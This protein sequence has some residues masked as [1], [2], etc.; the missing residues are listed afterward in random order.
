MKTLNIVGY[1]GFHNFGDDLMLMGLL[2][3]LSRK[4][5]GQVRVFV[6]HKEG[7]EAFVTRWRNLDVGFVSL[8]KFTTVLLPYYIFSASITIWCGGTCLYE[9]PSD[10]LFRGLKWI[11]RVAMYS[12]ISGRKLLLINIGVNRIISDRA[13]EIIRKMIVRRSTQIS[14][15]D[16]SSLENLKRISPAAKSVVLGGDLAFLN[17]IESVQKSSKNDHII[18]CGH[19]Q[20]ADNSD[21]VSFYAQ[22][23]SE[24]SKILGRSIV[25]VS[26]HDGVAGDGLF[27]NRIKERM[28]CQAVCTQY[29]SGD[30]QTLADLFLNSYCVISMRLHGVVFAE[31][32]MKPSIGIA[33]SDKVRYFVE[34]TNTVSSTRIKKVGEKLTYEDI[35]SIVKSYKADKS[36]IEKERALAVSG[37]D[38][39]L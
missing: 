38:A 12:E 10:P 20:Y 11:G 8:N 16:E 26:L 21:V 6:K 2:D 7:L 28:E 9:D 36:F 37:I 24:I 29:C 22:A 30:I 5:G 4:G 3:E 1:L 27:H 19:L 35:N 32:L 34:K 23:L 17:R 15:R 13:A 14:V 18:F 39:F 25:M 31:L 33:Y